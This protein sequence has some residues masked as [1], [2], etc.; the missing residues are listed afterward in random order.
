[1]LL[2]FKFKPRLN[3]IAN[4]YVLRFSR[5]TTRDSCT[6]IFESKQRM[7][8]VSRSDM[9][10]ECTHTTTNLWGGYWEG[11]L[12]NDYFYQL[13]CLSSLSDFP[14][15][16]F[17][18]KYICGNFIDT[19]WLECVHDRPKIIYTSCVCFGSRDIFFLFYYDTI[20]AVYI[21]KRTNL[22]FEYCSC[23]HSSSLSNDWHTF[24]KNKVTRYFSFFW[25]LRHDYRVTTLR[26][27]ENF[28]D[29]V[30]FIWFFTLKRIFSAFNFIL[31]FIL[32]CKR[33]IHLFG[34]L[35]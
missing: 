19:C 31:R 1:M 7:H 6:K 17:W 15:S 5:V 10:L 11:L 23:F 16:Q 20:H 12:T 30:L 8:S 26:V 27:L 4:I 25:L 3:L 33:N 14:D 24:C 35:S 13:G 2:C 18:R 28:N 34:I 9:R 29:F 32:D 21:S 22:G